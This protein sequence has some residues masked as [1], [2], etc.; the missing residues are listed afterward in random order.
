MLNFDII[1]IMQGSRVTLRNGK[2]KR[3]ISSKAKPRV[4]LTSLRSQVLQ[5]P[6]QFYQNQHLWLTEQAIDER[7]KSKCEA[8][9]VCYVYVPLASCDIH[10]EGDLRQYII[11][12]IQSECMISTGGITIYK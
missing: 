10:L 8:I 9:S 6:F 2:P 12:I 4:T 1:Q 5:F 7:N 3:S 11:A